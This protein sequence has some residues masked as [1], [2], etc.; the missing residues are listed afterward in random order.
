MVALA[1]LSACSSGGTPAID[2][3]RAW[4]QALVD[5][6]FDTVLKLT[7]TNSR[8]RSQIELKLDP[9]FNAQDKLEQYKGHFD[10]SG[11]K[12]EE[13]SSSSRAATVRLSGKMTIAAAGIS[14]PLE[15]SED[16]TVVNENGAW[17]VCANPIDIR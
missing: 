3:T 6:N 9:L 12:F 5:F 17:K 1:L 15:V 14:E 10:F 16:I 2:A 13:I 8:V 7:C 4:F 11:L